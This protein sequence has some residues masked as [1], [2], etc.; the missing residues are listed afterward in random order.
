VSERNREFEPRPPDIPSGLDDLVFAFEEAWQR[1]QRPTI[2]DY[3]PREG[4]LRWTA[5][6]EL[7]H[8]DLEYRLKA[9]EPARVEDYLARYP[10][11]AADPEVVCGLAAAEFRLRLAAGETVSVREYG[12]RFPRREGL[13]ERLGKERGPDTAV[14]EPGAMPAPRTSRARVR[15][16][17]C[18]HC[19]NPIQLVDDRQDEVLCPGCGSSFRVRDTRQTNTISAMR[20]LGKFQLLER[21]GL[22]AFGAVWRARDTELDKVVAL[23]IPHTGLLTLRDELERFHREARAAAQLRHPGIVTVHAILTLD[24]LPVIVSDFITGVPLGDLLEVRRLTAREAAALLAQVADAVDYAH[25]LKVIH[26]DLK[27]ANIMIERTAASADGDNASP[28][29]V[30]D[31]LAQIGKPVVTDFGLALREGAEVTMT[32]DGVP[33]GTLAYMSP[34]QASGQGHHVDRRS[35]VYSLGVILYELLTGELPFRGSRPMV[36]YQLLHEEPRSPRKVNDKI[37]RDLETICLKAMAKQPSNRYESA[38]AMADDLRNWLQGLPIKARPIGKLERGWRWCRR[39]PAA[40]GMLVASWVAVLALG[41]LV[42][43]SLSYK[44]LTDSYNREAVAHEEAQAALDQATLQKYYNHVARAQ[45]A[46]RDGNLK[47]VED[48]LETCPFESRSWEWS[49]LKRSCQQELLTFKGHSGAVFGVAFSPDGG[50][51]ASVGTEGVVKVWYSATGSEIL[52]LK[53]GRAIK[54]PNGPNE[55]VSSVA[56][57]P[58]GA[59]LAAGTENGTVIIWNSANGEALRRLNQHHGELLVRDVAFS[60]DGAC[61][62]SCGDDGKIKVWTLS[63]NETQMIDVKDWKNCHSVAFDRTGTQL[64]AATYGAPIAG[65]YDAPILVWDLRTK[66]QIH[67]LRGH[68]RMVLDG[69]FS[70]DGTYIASGSE[71]RTVRL[72]DA[73][74]GSEQRRLTGHLSDVRSVAFSQDGKCLA[75]GSFD[76]TVRIW[77]P[78]TGAEIGCLKGH[79][80]GVRKVAFSPDGVKL[81]SAS[82]D[83]TVKIWGRAAPQDATVLKSHKGPVYDGVFSADST[84]VATGEEGKIVIWDV[85]MA[86]PL[87]Q[88]EG[89]DGGVRCVSFSPDGH[90]LASASTDGRVRVWDLRTRRVSL[91]YEDHISQAAKPSPEDNGVKGVALAAVG[92]RA[93]SVSHDKTVRLWDARSGQTLKTWRVHVLMNARVAFSPDGATLAFGADT[94]NISIVNTTSLETLH[95]LPVHRGTVLCVAFSGHRLAAGTNFGEIKIWDTATGAEVVSIDAHSSMI[96]CVTFSP[97]GKRLVSSSGDQTIKFWDV[98]NGQEVMCLRAHKAEVWSVAFSPDGTRLIS[99]SGDGTALIWDARPRT[100][101]IVAEREA[102]NELQVLSSLGRTGPDM[103]AHLRRSPLLSERGRQKALE[104]MERFLSGE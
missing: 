45:A 72:W 23:K 20:P 48:L 18:P 103:K 47:G 33:I 61:L 75:S 88:L 98:P 5:L 90:R 54:S 78:S 60:P 80:A 57:S 68:S 87:M 13:L 21:V 67:T 81:A 95:V 77:D 40:A 102:V 51:V 30:T 17:R 37:P 22:G 74:A 10:E 9:G 73:N 82:M 89:H 94:G 2:D 52:S 50:R 25:S 1:G 6:V 64:A 31:P 53:T 43:A 12:E 16:F 63:N 24:G 93:A 7:V 29:P 14:P 34:Q 36:Q 99:T 8:I 104:L 49:Y 66:K 97:D 59:R 85:R 79:C 27:P 58:D 91:S 28:P 71:D 62:A 26:R 70:P 46:W 35:D 42:V 15:R 101:E 56:W 100:P 41:G 55:P 76:G 92:D 44:Q 65:T 3:L 19:H 11:L 39:N 38:R 32:M 86:R 96:W 83:G 84:R 69:R 4:A